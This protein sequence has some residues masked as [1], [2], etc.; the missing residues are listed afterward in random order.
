MVHDNPYDGNRDKLKNF[1]LQ[2]NL[3]IKGQG[4]RFHDDQQKINWAISWLRGRALSWIEPKLANDT[5]AFATWGEF[6]KS[7]QATFGDPDPQQTAISKLR[8]LRQKASVSSYWSEFQTIAIETKWDNE[9]LISQF[10]YGLKTE[11][12]ERYAL[13][14]NDD[15]TKIDDLAA[16]AIKQDIKMFAFRRN[17]QTPQPPRVSPRSQPWVPKANREPTI[18]TG[19]DQPQ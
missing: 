7:L 1:L 2:C 4:T 11:L 14:E 13:R 15:Y 18:P 5:I 17:R 6:T 10:L 8:E 3:K 19:M 16:W 9:A 12:Q